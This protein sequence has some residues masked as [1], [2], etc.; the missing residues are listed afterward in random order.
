MSPPGK[1]PAP[2]EMARRVREF[3]WSS[4][5]LGPAE[6]WPVSLRINVATILASQFPMS[7]RWGPQLILI[8]NDAFRSILGDRHPAA[9]GRPGREVWGEIYDVL[10]PLS[11]AI[12]KGQRGAFFREDLRWRLRRR[13]D[14]PEDAQFT[15]GFSPIPDETA[16]NGIGGL[17]TTCIETTER[18]QTEEA[19]RSLTGSLEEQ[20]EERTRERDRIW[21]VS[22]D[23]LGVTNFGGYFVNVN[24]AW[25]AVLGWTADEIRRMHV[26][27]LRHPDDAAGA[28]EGR[29]R[30]A[31]GVPTVRI[32]NRFRHKDGS[33][34]WISWTMTAQEALIYVIGRDVTAEKEAAA[35]LLRVQGQLAQ[36]QKMEAIGQLTGGIAHDFNNLLMIIG[37]NAE[38]LGRRSTEPRSRRAIE[39]IQQAAQRGEGLTRQLLSFSRRQALNPSVVDLGQRLKSFRDLLASSMRGNIALEIDIPAQTWPVLVDA[40]ELELALVNVAVNA[41][42]AMPDGGAIRITAHNVEVRPAD[43]PDGIAG[44]FVALAVADSGTGIDETILPKV[45]DPFFTTK[46]QYEG[47]GLGL[48]QVYGFSRQSGGTVTIASR[49]GQ[50]TTLTLYLPR[51]SAAAVREA[52][53]ALPDEAARNHETILLV[54]DNPEVLDVAA[55]LL[56]ELGYAVRSVDSAEAALGLLATGEQIDLVF[57]DVVMP[58]KLD[59]IALAERIRDEHPHIRVLLTS[60]YATL[61][62]T[63]GRGVAILRKPYRMGTLGRAVREALDAPRAL[64]QP[65]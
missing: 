52:D 35:E 27:E 40:S 17:L 42:D 3:D 37:G 57:S 11:E 65:L 24:P 29:A 34:R 36:S 48:S 16:P 33:W 26:N 22:E 44:A 45:F 5:P 56:Q 64:V 10:G 55:T 50:G 7:V 12:L 1:Q 6:A 14:L 4:T 28:I 46:G 25:T 59:G 60:G 53:A 21:R 9:L 38:T 51:S 62:N 39:A 61:G 32:E 58:G 63:A 47:T 20:V 43:T 23:L 18:V 2:G 19:L 8:Y 13:G 30:L 49:L 31:A 41:R 54:E 15:I